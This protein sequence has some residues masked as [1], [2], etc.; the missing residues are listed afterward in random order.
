MLAKLI[1]IS[2]SPSQCANDVDI[3]FIDT[4]AELAQEVLVV[5]RA[6]EIVALYI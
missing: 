5:K 2:I 1:V 3:I 4:L 6:I